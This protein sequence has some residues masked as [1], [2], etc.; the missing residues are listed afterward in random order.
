VIKNADKNFYLCCIFFIHA[1]DTVSHDQLLKKM[2]S[3]F[4]IGGLAYKLLE[5]YLTDRKQYTK[6]IKSQIA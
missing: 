3:N 5:N 6:N 4:G 2:Q 1:F